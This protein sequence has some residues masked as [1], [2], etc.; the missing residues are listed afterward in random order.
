MLDE[1]CAATEGFSGRALRKLPFQTFA[2]KI[3]KRETSLEE[4]LKA[5]GDSAREESV[6]MEA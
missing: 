2:R 3:R 6:S 5:L 4:F 1:C